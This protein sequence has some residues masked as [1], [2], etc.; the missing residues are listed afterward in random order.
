MLSSVAMNAC[1][2]SVCGKDAPSLEKSHIDKD[3]ILIVLL[4]MKFEIVLVE[5]DLPA[6]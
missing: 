3:I 5:R 4:L 6:N 1:T 2:V